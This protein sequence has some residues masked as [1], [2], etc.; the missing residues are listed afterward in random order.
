MSKPGTIKPQPSFSAWWR[1]LR[2]KGKRQAAKMERA[3]VKRALLDGEA[4][5]G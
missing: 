2:A 5:R 3:S 1:H 4:G